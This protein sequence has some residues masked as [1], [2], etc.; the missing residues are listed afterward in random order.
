MIPEM[1][2]YPEVR[3]TVL[4]SGTSTGVP[5]INCTCPVCTSDNPRN[6]RLRTSIKLNINGSTFLVDCGVDFR[7]QMLKFH[8]PRIDA[9]L[10][11]HTHADHVHG[12]DDLRAFCFR[13]LEHIPIYT[14]HRFIKDIETR[15]A[16]AFDPPQKGGGVP[17]L[18]LQEIHAGQLF[19]IQDVP[20]LPLRIM[21]GKL[22]I[23]GFRF[24]KFAYLTD[25]SGIPEETVAQ[26]EGVET[27]I[28]SALRD[29]PHPT[30]FS[31]DQAMEAAKS[32]GVKKA[33][34][35]HFTCS[36]DHEPTEAK[37]PE[38]ARLAYDGLELV[39]PASVGD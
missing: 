2:N 5:V 25:C 1:A 19:E 27:I 26:L 33:Y 35:I 16:Y 20:I 13:Q 32:L 29:R 39:M 38:W 15:F 28:L 31:F 37:L 24:G 22:Q 17:M 30:H 12:I 10:I 3:I 21:H 6:K 8:T 34:F 36:V 4:G 7:Q 9:V 14:T 23:L 11:T 18:D